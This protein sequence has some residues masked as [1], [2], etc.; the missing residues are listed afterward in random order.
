MPNTSWLL[1]LTPLLIP[2]GCESSLTEP[3][4]ELPVAPA[5]GPAAGPE[6]GAQDGLPAESFDHDYTVWS[7]L[8]E[9]HVRGDRFD[10][11]ALSESRGA[12][13]E[14]L[15]S[16]RGVRADDFEGWTREQRYAFWINAYNAFTLHLVLTR[17]P[18]PSIRDLGTMISPVWKKKFIPLGHLVPGSPGEDG[19]KISLDTVEHG[20]LR[21][22]FEDARVHAAVNCASESCPPLRAGAFTAQGLDAQLDEQARAWLADPQ[23]NRFLPGKRRAE[24]SAI[25]DWFEADFVR[26]AGS[27]AGWLAEY[28]PREHADWLRDGERVKIDHLD[29]S[30]K[31]NDVERPADR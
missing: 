2:T 4:A 14:V 25:F 21:P 31:L 28:G 3:G 5:S 11:R 7:G 26:D 27:V 30:W 17:Y 12:L 9:R 10:Y 22:V 19:S 6:A 8:L 13:D 20:I 18:L 15:L 16:M 29:Y 23:R 24:V 1:L